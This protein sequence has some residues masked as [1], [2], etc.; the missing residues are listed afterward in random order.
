MRAFSFASKKYVILNYYY[1]NRKKRNA[2]KFAPQN[3]IIC[4]Q[5]TDIF[6]FQSFKMKLLLRNH[7]FN[8]GWFEI[9]KVYRLY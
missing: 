5:D 8:W 7:I 1:V 6:Q 2:R 9:S 4:K 3:R